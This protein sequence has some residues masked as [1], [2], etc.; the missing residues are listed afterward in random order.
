MV[1]ILMGAEYS[2]KWIYYNSLNVVV[3]HLERF[4]FLLS[5]NTSYYMTYKHLMAY[6]FSDRLHQ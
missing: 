1:N 3:E 2:G 6:G 4:H 5:L